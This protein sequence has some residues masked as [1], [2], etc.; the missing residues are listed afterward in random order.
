MS[1]KNP[2]GNDNWAWIWMGMNPPPTCYSTRQVSEYINTRYKKFRQCFDSFYGIGDFDYWDRTEILKLSNVDK[3]E[4]LKLLIEDEI[5]KPNSNFLDREYLGLNIDGTL[6]LNIPEFK[7]ETRSDFFKILTLEE[8]RLRTYP[9]NNRCRTD[10]GF[11]CEDCNHIF[12]SGSDDYI[13][14]ELLSIAGTGIWNY[15]AK[16]VGYEN[17]AAALEKEI[18]KIQVKISKLRNEKISPH[19]LEMETTYNNIEH[20]AFNKREKSLIVKLYNDIVELTK[21]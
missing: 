7:Y 2:R 9:H 1:N 6:N 10:G 18:E 4:L 20:I 11:Y 12:D 14:L 16:Y 17:D 3:L 13:K 5:R 8:C 21:K 15:K 19:I